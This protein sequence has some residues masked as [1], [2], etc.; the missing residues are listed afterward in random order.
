MTVEEYIEQKQKIV[1]ES[2]NYIYVELEDWTIKAYL[3][4]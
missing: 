1:C 3:K 4:T 2:K